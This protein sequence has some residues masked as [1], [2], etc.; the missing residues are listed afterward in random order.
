[1][2]LKNILFMLVFAV[3][4]CTTSQKPSNDTPTIQDINKK[5][6]QTIIVKDFDKENIASD[7]IEFSQIIQS[8]RKLS[9]SDLELYDTLFETYKSL[10]Y[11]PSENKIKIPARTKLI[12]P[13]KSYCLDS[14]KASP[15]P[16]EVFKWSKQ[17]NDIPYLKELLKLSAEKKYDQ[18]LIQ[19][20]IWNIKNKT[21]WENYPDS[22]KEIL[23]IIDPDASTNMPSERS[24]K[25][26]SFIKD[27][28]IQALPTDAQ[29]KINYVSGKFYN[30]KTLKN[31]LENR[32][33]NLESPIS[34]I[35][36]FEN[37]SNLYTSNESDNFSKQEV[38]FY[39]TSDKPI[40]I[41]LTDY[42]QIPSRSDVQRLAAYFTDSPDSAHILKQLE[43]LLYSDMA[44]YGYGFIPV[45]NDLIDLYE[46]TSGNNFFT[47]DTLSNQERFLSA[48]SLVLGNAE[49]YRQASKI[50]N[51]PQSYIDDAFKKYRNI[52]N[53]Q[54]YKTLE[55]LAHDLKDRSIPDDWLKL[56]IVKLM[57]LLSIK[58][59]LS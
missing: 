27:K 22:Y 1:M 9:S 57:A 40:A 36:E 48:L 32:K 39:N 17:N 33:S 18:E 43:K 30:F 54:S 25:V 12:I 20:L 59:R 44:K 11:R 21:Y 10:K 8:K 56:R 23:K 58:M 3:T 49:A 6:V 47:N 34:N 7:I 31:Q 14:N 24:K 50:F 28:V 37:I 52:K 13:F 4:S 15:S 35:A 5:I 16:K 29:D 51:G 2:K 53:E 45:L 41:A 46:V 55:K 19:E 26:I 38:S 42:E